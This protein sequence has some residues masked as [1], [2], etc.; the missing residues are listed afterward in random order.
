MEIAFSFE[1]SVSVYKTT[2]SCN[3]EDHNLNPKKICSVGQGP[4]AN[5]FNGVCGSTY[6]DILGRIVHYLFEFGILKIYLS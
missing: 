3:P 6:E 5:F 1:T 4:I 2:Q